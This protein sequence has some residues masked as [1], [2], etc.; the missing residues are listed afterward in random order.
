MDSGLA[1][2]FAS[3]EQLVAAVEHL[4]ADGYQRLETFTPFQVPEINGLLGVRRSKIPRWVLAGGIT[5]GSLAFLF[6]WW[7]SA[8]DYPLIIG[9][10]PLNSA[11]AFIPITFEATVL[12]AGT[13]A[14]L[15]FLAYCWL[16]RP[17]QPIF[18]AEGFESATVDKFW[19]AID[20]RDPHFADTATREHLR[21]L[22]PL[23]ISAFG[24]RS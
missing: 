17:A 16:P 1:A 20:E 11:P 23:R 9:G 14:L 19:L 4:R 5:G 13:T 22:H 6:Q 8:I 18:S 3:P 21:A 12:S 2:E 10:R 24:A 15:A 7:T